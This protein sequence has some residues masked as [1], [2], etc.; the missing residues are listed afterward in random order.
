[1]KSLPLRVRLTND[2][3]VVVAGL[4]SML[5]PFADRINVVET[6][7]RGQA[8]QPVDL[9]LYDTFGRAQI[10]Q[11]DIDEVIADPL[12]G[13]VILY[14]WNTHEDLVSA[15]LAKGSWGY[16]SKSLTASELVELLERVGGGEVVRPK[17]AEAPEQQSESAGVWP[18]RREG[19]SLREA[20][21]IA[22]ITQGY[23]N[24]EIAARIYVTVNSLKS[25]IR[26]AYRKMGVERRAQA[27]RW[28]I[29]HGML[30]TD[31]S[32]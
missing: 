4:R 7:V 1:M 25:Y 16:L 14:S 29:S 20:E 13:R 5:A 17:S 31:E 30:P 18:G 28:G 9:T 22:L 26:S 19:L 11:R 21:V 32:S 12:S 27:V 10:D 2:Y 3:E 6:D 15:A 24:P 8:D 23:T